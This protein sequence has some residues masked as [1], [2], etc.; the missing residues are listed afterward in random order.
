M[1]NPEK[2][3]RRWFIGAG[4]AAAVASTAWWRTRKQPY[5]PQI[6]VAPGERVL[7]EYPSVDVHS[8]PGRSFLGGGEFDSI[9][10]N[11]MSRG[12]EA[13]R[14]ADMRSGNVTASLFSFVA[15][16]KVL[17]LSATG[18][19]VADREFAAGEAYADFERQLTYFKS[20]VD[21]G[22]LSCAH[23]ADE[24]RVAHREGNSVAVL[25]SEGADFV[26]NKLERL[27][28]AY[29]A[30]IRAIT[31]LHYRPSEYGDNQTSASQHGGLTPL[32][33]DLIGEM[34]RLGIVVDMA[35]AS[36][37]T[38]RDAVEIASAPLM[39]SHSHLASGDAPNPRLITPEH[40]M[41]VADNGGVIGSWPAGI[42]S[43][44]MSDFVD[45]TFR[46][47]DQ[48]GIDHVAVGTDLDANYKP[49]LTDY[50]QF[51]EFASMLLARGLSDEEAGKV[52]GLNF[53]RV[54]DAVADARI[55]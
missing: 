9:V 15:D 26:E 29:N 49:V 37:E 19:I 47:I 12:F 54:F 38:V 45:V 31:L 30:G 34:N 48:V 11:N 3:S 42:T 55:A 35:H 32:G 27:T 23:S 51:P 46:L 21:T 20:L 28:T 50:I 36:F 6:D 18:G 25:S 2:K 24:V 17:G 13:E 53:L 44:T 52:L 41:L 5:V 33:A 43:K 4:V 22:V 7:A 40:A 16:V 14:I 8:H 39:L 1:R 10:I